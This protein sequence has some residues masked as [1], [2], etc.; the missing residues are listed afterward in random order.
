MT[1][2]PLSQRRVLYERHRQGDVALTAGVEF[3]GADGL[4][5]QFDAYSPSIR[6]AALRPGVVLVHGYP[7]EGTRRIVGCSYKD[8]GAAVSWGRLIAM[9]GLTAVAYTNRA[10][11]P[12]LTALLHHLAANGSAIGIDA[13][14]LGVFACSGH[15]PLALSCLR[16]GRTPRVTCAALLYGYMLDSDGATDVADAQ[17]QFRFTNPGV[18]IADLAVDTPLLVVRAGHDE[19]PGLNASL[20][21]FVA[22]ALKRNLPVT[23]ANHPHAP[24]AFD[25]ALDDERTRGAIKQVLS[26]LAGNLTGW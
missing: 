25:L 15:V 10:P 14:R 23:V 16:A 18:A 26:F 19:M 9:A 22:E 3:A 8:T 17:Q 5:L 12:D 20:D 2:E 6:S 4:P 21:R 24:H 1:E 11:E 13:S 7:D